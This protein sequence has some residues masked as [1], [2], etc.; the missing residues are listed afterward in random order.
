M[1]ALNNGK[2]SQIALG[3]FK[4]HQIELFK[5]HFPLPANPEMVQVS[6]SNAL[7][8]GVLSRHSSSNALDSQKECVSVN[9]MLKGQHRQR[10]V[11]TVDH[12]GARPTFCRK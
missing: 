11:P 8:G 12:W 6:K 4:C 7:G 2:K 3:D 9:K 10:T 5:K 1:G